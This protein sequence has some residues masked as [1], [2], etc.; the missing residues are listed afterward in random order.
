MAKLHSI[1]LLLVIPLLLS[2]GV[3]AA[4]AQ[5]ADPQFELIKDITPDGNSHVFGSAVLDGVMYLGIGTDAVG[6]GDSDT[7]SLWRT[8]GTASGTQWIMDVEA[9]QAIAWEIATNGEM[10]FFAVCDS[11]QGCELWTSDGTAAGSQL[12]KD[13]N[14]AGDGI[15]PYSPFSMTVMDGIV[16]FAADDGVHGEELWRS[17]GTADGTWMVSDSASGAASSYPYELTPVNGKLYYSATGEYEDGGELWVSDGTAEGTAMVANINQAWSGASSHPTHITPFNGKII[18]SAN[19][20]V[21][22]AELWISDG[23]PG[24]ETVMVK[25]I[26]PGEDESSDPG[27]LTVMDGVLY[28]TARDEDHGRELWKT[29]G[30]AD[31]TAIAADIWPGQSEGGWT[32]SSE[33]LELTVLNGTLYF[34]AYNLNTGLELWKFD[35]KTAVLVKDIYPGVYSSAPGVFGFYVFQDALYFFADD[36][37]HG[38][39][40]WTATRTRGARLL[41]SIQ[42]KDGEN[43]PGIV[44]G[45]GDRLLMLLDDGINGTELWSYQPPTGCSIYLPLVGR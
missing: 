42:P 17:D 36:G 21:H 8:D 26:F 38:L 35:G 34:G 4:A 24:G 40:P 13:I 43:Y 39:Q 29:D 3:G 32:K 7:L 1:F 6:S 45:L 9:H 33:P 22:G 25:D 11:E 5:S 18:F 31:G 27:H 37:E 19:D 23:I 41:A 28:F 14:P 15:F 30:T 12:L 16:Y 44:S 10:L 20:G 2:A